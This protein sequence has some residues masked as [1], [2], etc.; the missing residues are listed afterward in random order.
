LIFDLRPGYPAASAFA[1][2]DCWPCATSFQPVEE[3]VEYREWFID[4]QGDGFW[5]SS[6]DQV[7]RRFE[8]RRAGR[9]HR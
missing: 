6:R 7:H 3:V 8:T 2:R 1:I 4:R 9:G 5:R